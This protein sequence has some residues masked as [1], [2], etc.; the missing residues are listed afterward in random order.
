LAEV[1][2]V[3]VASRVIVANGQAFGHTGPYEKLTG[4]NE[5]VVED[6]DNVM[7]RGR[8]PWQFVAAH[9]TTSSR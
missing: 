5:F 2:R 8:L 7:K 3:N 1:T 6:V 4:T 9:T